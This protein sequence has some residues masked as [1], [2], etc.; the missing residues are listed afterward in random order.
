MFLTSL[1]RPKTNVTPTLCFR[2]QLS[3]LALTVHRCHDSEVVFLTIIKRYSNIITI[4]F[5]KDMQYHLVI[6]FYDKQNLFYMCQCKAFV[7]MVDIWKFAVRCLNKEKGFWS[8]VARWSET[9]PCFLAVN[10]VGSWWNYF[11]RSWNQNTKV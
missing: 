1:I 5:L 6:P 8:F 2:R 4:F 7:Q 9:A 11:L 10:S 3:D